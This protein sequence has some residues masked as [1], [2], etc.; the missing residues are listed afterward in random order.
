[1]EIGTRR[2]AALVAMFA[3]VLAA[4][5]SA[6]TAT[7]EITVLHPP[8]PEP[9]LLAVNAGESSVGD[10]RIFHFD[11]ETD[12]GDPVTIDWIMTTTAID[13]PEVGVETRSSS[14]SLSF[15]SHNDQLI[16][17]GIALYPG[18][19]SVLAV[20]DSSQRAIVGGS[21]RFAGATG[22]I[23]STRL[24]DGSWRHEITLDR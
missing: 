16:V 1:M 13:A 24:D 10:V 21:G 5:G 23:V 11:G 2:L 20:A 8:V 14:A 3:L 9:T 6:A 4:C 7:S 18:A 12:T 17:E 19:G 15:G 22:E